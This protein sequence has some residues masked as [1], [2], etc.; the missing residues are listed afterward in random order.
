MKNIVMIS[1]LLI[2]F[3]TIS[4]QKS[5]INKPN[6]RTKSEKPSNKENL[7]HFIQFGIMSR[8]HEE[9]RKKYSIEVMYQNCVI[10]KYMSEKAKE[11]NKL[12]AKILT[13][14][15]GDSWKQDLEFTPY[16]L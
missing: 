14:K 2:S 1:I 8:N 13:E 11:N 3:A 15:H 5:K 7:Q 6:L 12:V 9:F 4:A 16:G 10:T